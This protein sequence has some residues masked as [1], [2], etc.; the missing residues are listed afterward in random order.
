MLPNNFGTTCSLYLFYVNRAVSSNTNSL[1]I[2]R[3]IWFYLAS[4]NAIKWI[5]TIIPST[6]RKEWTLN[7][8]KLSLLHYKIAE[9]IFLFCCYC[10]ST[11]MGILVNWKH[12]H[13]T[14]DNK[15]MHKSL[16]DW[17]HRFALQNG[18]HTIAVTV[19]IHSNA[20]QNDC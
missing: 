19:L 8:D 16:F 10:E 18:W 12:I 7:S 9:Y 5:S 3:D 14:R 1:F 2:K 20:C 13:N 17:L 4:F 6:I 15:K 11:P